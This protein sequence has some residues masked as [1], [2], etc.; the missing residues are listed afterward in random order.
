VFSV[1]INEIQY[2]IVTPFITAAFIVLTVF[3]AKLHHNDN[4][5]NNTCNTTGHYQQVHGHFQ[6]D[7]GVAKFFDS[8]TKKYILL[9]A[10]K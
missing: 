2:G 4:L 6:E 9:A 7:L 8:L 5:S 10:A 1:D 3:I